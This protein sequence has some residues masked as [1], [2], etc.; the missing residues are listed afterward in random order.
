MKKS[1]ESFDIYIYKINDWN[2][3]KSKINKVP[4]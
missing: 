2:K 1:K 4:I 3:N